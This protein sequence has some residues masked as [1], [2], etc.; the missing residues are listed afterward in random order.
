MNERK[1]EDLVDARL[2]SLGY[3]SPGSGTVIEKQ[4]SDSVRIQRLLEHAS[5]RGGGV[6]SL[7]S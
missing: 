5:K 3:Y 1:T 6:V 2:R 7:S 4:K